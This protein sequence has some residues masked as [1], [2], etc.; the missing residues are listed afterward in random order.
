MIRSMRRLLT[1][2]LAVVLML[3]GAA[4]AVASTRSKI[5]ADCSD[6]GQLQGR[7]SPSELRNARQHLPSD[8]AE[9]TDCADVLRR[10]EL[11]DHGATGGGT[12]PT[13]P[14]GAPV[15]PG[16]T[17]T[18]PPSSAVTTRPLTPTTDQ[19]RQAL[20]GA[21][22]SGSQPVTVDGRRL[23]PSTAAL[24]EGYKA[25]GLPSTVVIALIALALAGLALSMPPVRRVLRL[26][27][28]PR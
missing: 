13:T 4:P 21:L 6:D 9:Y 1:V 22:E 16:G 26:R 27:R 8:V 17:G 23:L 15:V 2:S 24:R 19:D 28:G 7:Y 11:P 10:A 5:I 14:P 12:G 25:N 20:A 18:P 3:L